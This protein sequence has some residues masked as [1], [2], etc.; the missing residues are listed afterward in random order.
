MVYRFVFGVWFLIIWKR[1]GNE[2][3]TCAPL[4]KV[5][6]PENDNGYCDLDIVGVFFDDGFQDTEAIRDTETGYGDRFAYGS[7]FWVQ[8]S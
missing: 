5:D 2:L 3:S 4:A 7:C 8:D 6:Q 1:Y